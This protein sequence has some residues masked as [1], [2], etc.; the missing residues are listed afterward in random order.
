MT[1]LCKR[2]EKKPTF[3]KIVLIMLMLLAVISAC[4][5]FLSSAWKSISPLK[6]IFLQG[7]L[8]V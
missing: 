7:D 4:H 6:T 2:I 3:W 5:C 8:Y 1:H